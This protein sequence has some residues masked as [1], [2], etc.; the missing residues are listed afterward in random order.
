MFDIGFGELVVV[1]I[2]ALVVLGPERLPAAARTLGR[3]I[4]TI[5]GMAQQVRNELER[6]L[7]THELNESL[8]KA[9]QLGKDVPKELAD[10]VDDM[11]RSA[12]ELDRPY[13]DSKDSHE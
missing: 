13:K 2:I 4:R 3:W 7:E 11:K 1:G 10:T 6:E 12:E 5:K 8:K 9:E